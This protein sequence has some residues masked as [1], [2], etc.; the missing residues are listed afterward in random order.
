MLDV[1]DWVLGFLLVSMIAFFISVMMFHRHDFRVVERIVVEPYE[2][3]C[4]DHVA[5][6][7]TIAIAGDID[8][9]TS[10][11]GQTTILEECAV[12]KKQRKRVFRG[13]PE[14]YKRTAWCS[15]EGTA[16]RGR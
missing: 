5:L 4:E 13:I 9:R 6:A 8:Y 1:Y 14:G 10:K 7:T 12:C 15:A 3:E 11:E 2:W 16:K